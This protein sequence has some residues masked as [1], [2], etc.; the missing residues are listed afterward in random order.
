[1]DTNAKNLPNGWNIGRI[2][3]IG[4]V[5]T[6]RTPSTKRPEFYSGAYNLISPADLDNGKYVIT[7]HKKLSYIGFSECRALPRDTILVGCIGN[8]GKLG[9]V[10]DDRSATNQQINGIICNEGNDPHYV[11]YCLYSNRSRL[12]NAADKTTVPI[13][14]KTNFENFEIAIP[15]LAEQRKIAGILGTVQ[16]A[17][18]QQEKLL[19]LTAELKKTLLQKLFTEGLRGEPQKQTEI[20]PV[21]KSWEVVPLISLLREPLRNGHS[22]RAT[23]DGTGIRTLTL[24]AVT[25]RNFADENT[26]LTSADPKRVKDMWLEDGDILV[27]RANTLEYVGLAALYEGP[28]AWAIYP[29]LMIRARVDAKRA[30]PYFIS[31]FL[32]TKVCRVYFQCHARSTAGNFPKIDQGTVENIPIPLP[33]INQQHDI[34]SAL[35]TVREKLDLHRRKHRSLTYLL[36]TLLHQLMTAQIRVSELELSELEVML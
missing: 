23:N 14:N 25:Q 15:P 8:V 5:I 27:E 28:S 12:E 7:C 6:G 31:E 16:R 17:I 32:T 4:N 21:P 1:M 26:K 9:M 2:G 20:G 19:Q 10:A 11:Y 3:E 30:L 13:L 24:T 33:D 36:R 35:R 18:E 22:A 34:S 29:D